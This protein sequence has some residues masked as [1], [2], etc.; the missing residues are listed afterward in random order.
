MNKLKISGKDL[1][2]IGYPQGSSIGLAIQ[3][4]EKRKIS[5]EREMVLEKLQKVV[6]AP[7]EFLGHEIF[8]ELALALTSKKDP[9][10]D[11]THEIDLLAE[12]KS[13]QVFGADHIEE[14]ALSQ[15][16]V[17]MKLPVALAGALMPDA[18]QGYG[19]PIG[20]VLSTA[21]SIIPYGVGVDIGCRMCLTVY[22]IPEEHFYANS[23][24]Y[25]RK[26]IAFT[27]FGAGNGW[28]GKDM[29]EHEVLHRN[30]FNEIPLVK[31]LYEKAASQLGTSGG[32]NH[33]VEWGIMEIEEDDAQTGLPKGKFLALLSHSG[34]RGFGA[35]I[36]AHYTKL[37]KEI[38]KLP[39]EARNLAYLDLDS[40]EG[41]EYWLAMNLAGDYASACHEVIH[42]RLTKAIKGQ[43][44]ARVENHHNFAW[45]EIHN[46][47]EV[48]VHRKGATPAAEG[49]LGII[50]GSMTAPGFL[51]RGK[52][53][54][55][56]MHSA[57]HGA[58]R[59][60]SRT[61]AIRTLQ[62]GDLHKVLKDHGVTLIG[63]GLDEAPMAYKDIHKVMEAQMD[64]VHTVGKFIPKMVRMADDGSRE[65]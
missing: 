25:K 6:Q 46:G 39:K 54:A 41:M 28:R 11:Y 55:D 12:E 9:A 51:V 60:M 18:H 24:F 45:K 63:A 34:S 50:P 22:D 65:D 57:S 30:T 35:T 26:L 43:V 42:D 17:A 13:F 47:Q 2:E 56:S 32:G 36:A 61:Q 53:H 62:K 21:N 19:L 52:G 7:D 27:K 1:L 31:S 20:G 3:L 38:C 44:L 48:V 58:G 4:I 15:M 40:D 49:V 64:L 33:F 59:Q 10:E 23:N 5:G 16:K 8:G 37:A 14:G 29:A